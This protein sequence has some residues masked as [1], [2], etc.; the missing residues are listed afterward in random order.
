MFRIFSYSHELS[1]SDFV[2]RDRYFI[3]YSSQGIKSEIFTYIRFFCALLRHIFSLHFVGPGC[4]KPCKHQRIDSEGI[5]TVDPGEEH[6]L[7]D[8]AWPQQGIGTGLREVKCS[9]VW[10][11]ERDYLGKP[12][13]HPIPRCQPRHRQDFFWREACARARQERRVVNFFVTPLISR[14]MSQSYF[15]Y[16]EMLKFVWLT[17]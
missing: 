1:S 13:I 7:L 16:Y 9:S 8:Q 3:S 5:R 2:V 12:L 10:C 11:Q 4:C 14:P 6:Y 17:L 15:V